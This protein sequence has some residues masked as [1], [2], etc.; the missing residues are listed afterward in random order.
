[1]FFRATIVVIMDQERKKL[2]LE[3]LKQSLRKKEEESK[4]KPVE[5]YSYHASPPRSK[6]SPP[7]R[8]KI[9]L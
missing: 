9:N 3:A 7:K 6:D 2:I 5:E 1:M 4:A 8:Y